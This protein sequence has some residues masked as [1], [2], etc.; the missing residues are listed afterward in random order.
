MGKSKKMVFSFFLHVDVTN[1]LL[2][3]II[4]MYKKEQSK[5]IDLQEKERLF[6]E[7]IA[8]NEQLIDVIARNNAPISG[9][10]DLEQ[11]I[12]IAFWKSLDAYDGESSALGT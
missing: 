12:R 9:W 1:G 3:E 4:Y 10:E 6:K 5:A 8:G 11:E 2:R 7:I